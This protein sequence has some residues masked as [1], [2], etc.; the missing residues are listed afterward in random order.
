MLLRFG[1][2]AGNCLGVSQPTTHVKARLPNSC[3]PRARTYSLVTSA[4]EIGSFAI[5]VK[6]RPGRGLTP[7]LAALRPGEDSWPFARTLTKSLA[8]PLDGS[9]ARGRCLVVVAFGVGVTEVVLTVRRALH[10]GQKVVLLIAERTSADVVFLPQL[11]AMA[12]QAAT[13]AVSSS[14]HNPECLLRL[15]IHFSRESPT[16]AFTAELDSLCGGGS[17]TAASCGVSAV[18]GR[19]DSAAVAKA[20]DDV[21]L[22]AATAFA[23]GSK[24]QMLQAYALLATAGIHQRLLG[25]PRLWG[26]W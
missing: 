15:T 13:K 3:I 11:C 17:G 22:A 18:H 25:R 16:A 21:D 26:C 2:P 5:A 8:A 7:L 19:I 23:V 14:S 4:E 20:V 6:I 10:A 9:D 1:L 12:S 24:P